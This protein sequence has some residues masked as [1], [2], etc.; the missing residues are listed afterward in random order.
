MSP[1]L[2]LSFFFPPRAREALAAQLPGMSERAREHGVERRLR[3]T[4]VC[5]CVCVC[6]TSLKERVAGGFAGPRRVCVLVLVMDGGGWRSTTRAVVK[7]PIGALGANTKKVRTP[8]PAQA[9]F[10][11]HALPRTSLRPAVPAG[12]SHAATLVP[13]P[14]SLLCTLPPR[15]RVR[16]LAARTSLTTHPLSPTH[17]HQARRSGA[18]R[19]ATTGAFAASRLQLA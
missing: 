10:L 15:R 4:G 1:S 11:L 8:H 2:S 9:G 18:G 12:T 13:T 14:P 6:K 19:P 17:P 16:A 7:V 5:V 3:G